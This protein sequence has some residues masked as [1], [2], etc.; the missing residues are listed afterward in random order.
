[1]RVFLSAGVVALAT[2]AACRPVPTVSLDV[3]PGASSF[4]SGQPVTFT[5]EVENT[6]TRATGIASQLDGTI[7]ILRITKDGAAV[8][9]RTTEVDFGQGLSASLESSLRS[10]APGNRAAFP[11]GSMRDRV[12]GQVL[13]TVAAGP[14]ESPTATFYPVGTAGRYEMIVEYRYPGPRGAFSSVAIGPAVDT[15][16][17]T[18]LP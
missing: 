10:V 16:R 18:I 15:V 1:M 9:G 17:F 3:R 14:N 7:A 4:V 6:G 5:V 13:R 8:A 12:A 11:W 2:A